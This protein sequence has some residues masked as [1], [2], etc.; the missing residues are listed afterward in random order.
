MLY[1][2]VPFMWLVSADS[3]IVIFC[4]LCR[5]LLVGLTLVLAMA[6]ICLL[7]ANAR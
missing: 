1:Y 4:K 7:L 3:R 6:C 2:G 5:R